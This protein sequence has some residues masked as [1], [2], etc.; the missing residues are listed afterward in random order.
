[1]FVGW[2]RASAAGRLSLSASSTSRSVGVRRRSQASKEP[3]P[4]EH[5]WAYSCRVTLC[6]DGDGGARDHSGVS[7]ADVTNR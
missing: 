7:S 1:V 2:Q 5:P 3:P 4:Q 6:G